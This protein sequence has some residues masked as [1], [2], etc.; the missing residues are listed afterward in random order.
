[1]ASRLKPL[2]EQ[3]IVITGASSGIGLATARRA[4]ARGARVVLTAR[5]REAL[6]D[7]AEELRRGGAEVAVCVADVGKEADVER[8][9]ATA[10][11][12]FGGFDTWVNCA[13]VSDYGTLDE[14][15][16]DEHR[17]LFE[18]NYFGVL[19]GSLVALD[20]LRA[21]GGG[22]IINMG[23]ILSDRSIIMQ[24][25]YSASKHAVRAL[26]EGLRMDID[27]EGLPISV[28]LIKPTGIHTPFPEHARNH[29][30]AP[31]RV[32]QLVYGPELVADAILFAAEHPRRQIYV[33]GNGF[34]ISLFGRLFPRLTD[35]VM[36]LAMVRGQQSPT[37]PGD[38]AMRDNLYEPKRD[39]Q[40]EG[41]Q[42]VFVR[43]SSLFLEA[44][45]RPGAVLALGSGAALAAWSL[46][47][48]RRKAVAKRPRAR[49]STLISP[50]ADQ[51]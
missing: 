3:T 15:G 18:V 5:N 1:M 39:G 31:P 6:E 14:I 2:N 40:V 48:R 28:T 44:Q 37:D 34:L 24:G 22:A 17:R 11:E 16:M 19:K 41:N 33:G 20:H 45:K 30:D 49:R 25:P 4:A 35:R 8:I 7:I 51:S 13:A 42:Q 21:S 32:P 9:A 10:I 47:R 12:A 38:P 29:M 26:T 46:A 43:R 36:E 50:R 27:R 23:S